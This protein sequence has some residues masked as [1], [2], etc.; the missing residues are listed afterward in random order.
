VRPTSAITL[1]TSL[2]VRVQNVD[3]TTF[4]T[5]I[6]AVAAIGS[7]IVAWAARA[8][9]RRAQETASGS[10]DQAA[11]LAEKCVAALDRAN[12]LAEMHYADRL[13]LEHRRR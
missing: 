9:S 2:S 11:Q 5:G 3:L 7:A 1:G 8:G 13:E 12:K 6:A 4:Y 10:Q